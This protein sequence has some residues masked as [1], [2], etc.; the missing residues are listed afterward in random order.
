MFLFLCLF[1]GSQ[2]LL[3]NPTS[4]LLPRHVNLNTEMHIIFNLIIHS[5]IKA[6]QF[7]KKNLISKSTLLTIDSV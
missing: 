2:G 4:S 7:G 3:Q 5:A 6:R 1:F